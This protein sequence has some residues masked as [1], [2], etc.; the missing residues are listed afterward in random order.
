MRRV[1]LGPN[2]L[3]SASLINRTGAFNA[4]AMTAAT[5]IVEQVRAEGDAALRQ[6]TL[7]F[8][9]VEVEQL[10]V[11][12]EEIAAARAAVA[13]ETLAALQKAADQIREFH[14]RQVEQS[15]FFARG[16]GALV[17]AKITPLDS[18]GI[19]VPGGRA[20]Y[21]STVLMNAVP[22]Q[23]AGVRRIVCTTP[24]TKSG[25]LDPAI[26]AACDIA[27]VTEIYKVGGAQAI[28][29]LA[30]GTA[31]IA[32]VDKITGPGNAF[33]AAAKKIVSGDVGVDMIAGPSEVCVVADFTAD[34]K[35]VAI[36]LMAQA[37]HDPLAACYLVCFSQD[38]ADAVEAAVQRHLADSSRADI[39][40]SSLDNEGLCVVCE[41]M[42]QALEAVNVIAPEHL[43]LHVA[44]AMDLLGAIRNAGA[45]F[46]GAWTPEAVGDYVAGPN[47]TLPT[48]GTARWAS[49]L[50]TDDFVK[51]SSIIQ[52]TPAALARDGETVRTIA[53]HEGLWAHARS[54]ELRLEELEAQGLGAAGRAVEASRG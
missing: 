36:D 28:G 54:V 44:D 16:D 50:S 31:S 9:G 14:E 34:P 24:P 20:L 8:D 37:E 23:V 43:E 10:R 42:A 5:A 39:T 52:Y 3:F 46:L 49:P 48:G 18:V 32:P 7:K 29:A 6:L 2:D 1:V 13:P 30:Y 11:S 4:S 22:A 21:P 47:H 12:E 17:G 38:Y 25:A 35:L 26:L 53:T 41:T 45:I 51:K 15:W 40:Q 27:G 33:V 19:Y